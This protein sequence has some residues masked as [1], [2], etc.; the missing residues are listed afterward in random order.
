MTGLNGADLLSL[1]LLCLVA[2]AVYVAATGAQRL[3][4]DDEE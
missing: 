1:C 3:S 4:Q 2:Y